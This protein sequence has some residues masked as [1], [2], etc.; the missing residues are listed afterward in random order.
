PAG[1]PQASGSGSAHPG[2]SGSAGGSSPRRAHVS[3]TGSSGPG[4]T[5]PFVAASSARGGLD[6]PKSS[7]TKPFAG[8]CSPTA[9]GRPGTCS[10]SGGAPAG[11]SGSAHR[12]ALGSGSQPSG[13]TP[14]G[15]SAAV[16]QGSGCGAAA[17]RPVDGG[18]GPIGG[19]DA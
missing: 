5:K 11:S 9:G 1:S 15:S 6:Q 18:T 14:T 10:G 19:V 7:A 8:G 4:G 17:W 3:G 16:G 13:G 2:C 12:S